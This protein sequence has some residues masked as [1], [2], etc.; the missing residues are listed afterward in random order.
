MTGYFLTKISVE[1]C[2]GSN[3]ECE[4][5]G[6]TVRRGDV[7]SVFAVNGVGKSSIFEAMCYAIQ[8][9]VPKLADLQVQEKPNE[10]ICNRFHSAGAANIQLEFKS[11]IGRA[12]GRE[13]V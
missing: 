10:Y 13:R 8:G 1:G 7:N 2:R 11:E 6:M 5:L 3:N 4:H 9:T 12:S